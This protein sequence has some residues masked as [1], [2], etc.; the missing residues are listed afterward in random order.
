VYVYGRLNRTVSI[1]ALAAICCASF[2]GQARAQSRPPATASTTQKS[3][4]AK[5]VATPAAKKPAATTTRAA[6]ARTRAA[7]ARAAALARAAAA[8]RLVREANTPR[9]KKD[10]LGNIVPD[11]RAAAAIV[12]NP[13]T[14]EVLWEA[15]S[16]D[17][18]SIASLTKIMT[19]VVF[20][21]DEPDLSRQ[22]TVVTADVRGANVTY[23]RAGEKLPLRD[24]L[25]LTLI[26]SDNA[27]ARILARTSEGGTPAFVGR[28]NDM[29]RQL[30]LTNSQYAD[31]SG[32]DARNVSSAYDVSH[33]MAFASAN[34]QLASVMSAAQYQVRT[35]RRVIK[36]H[37]TN[38]LLGTGMDI[39]AG[40]TGFI[41]KAGYC[42]ATLLQI[43][44]GS[45]VA[46]VVL[47]ATNSTLRFA[48]ARHLFNW[49]VGRA[50][51][52][53]GGGEIVER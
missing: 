17:R 47:G 52:L 44:H 2:V 9:F 1:A 53:V 48:E 42:F 13:Q 15:N 51:G 43:P 25:N 24:V 46:V 4:P 7:R 21:A 23:L 45:Q 27:A 29:A 6:A 31:P 34:P 39:V 19:G 11:V 33:L 38:K 28:M 50:N 16:H 12:F 37:S 41:K 30:G 32:L 5:P 10:A 20:I 36:I 18:R 3:T 40:K 14:N 35:N 26:A 22:V 49:V 8:A